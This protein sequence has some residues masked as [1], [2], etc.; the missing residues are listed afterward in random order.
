M[1]SGEGGWRM[2]Q[3]FL[4]IFFINQQF[5]LASQD[6]WPLYYLIIPNQGLISHGH[7]HNPHSI[8]T[9]IR[10]TLY[11][12]LLRRTFPKRLPAHPLTSNVRQNPRNVMATNVL[13]LT[14][15]ANRHHRGRTSSITQTSPVENRFGAT[16]VH[17]LF[18]LAH[19][20]TYPYMYI[21]TW[22]LIFDFIRGVISDIWFLGGS[23][24][25]YLIFKGVW[26]LS[27]ICPP[28]YVNI[29][30]SFRHIRQTS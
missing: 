19:N 29:F 2:T 8:Y 15:A 16:Y 28:T 20:C 14:T 21:N 12:R 7:T 17:T 4:Y 1:C 23:T 25:W 30:W 6:E 11:L 3:T 22:Y 10:N 13:A 9:M 5:C 27:D 18:T 24:I 26:Y